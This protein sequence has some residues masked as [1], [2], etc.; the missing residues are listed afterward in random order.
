[1]TLSSHQMPLGAVAVSGTHL[2]FGADTTIE[3]VPTG[4]GVVTAVAPVDLATFIAAD[5]V[6]LFCLSDY[7]PNLFRVTLDGGAI[8]TLATV[9][10][11][12][13]PASGLVIDATSVYWSEGS[14]G[15][16]LRVSKDGGTIST[17]ASGQPLYTGPLVGDGRYLYW[18]SANTIRGLELE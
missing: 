9:S 16:I 12:S 1:M 3:E 5:P 2:F 10:Y 11:N 8:S 6:S 13:S 4:G 18:S 17:L 7:T 14:S 15:Q